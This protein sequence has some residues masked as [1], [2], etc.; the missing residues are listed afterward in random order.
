MLTILGMAKLPSLTLMMTPQILLAH[1][2][3]TMQETQ[4]KLSGD[5]LIHSALTH[6]LSTCA[7]LENHLADQTRSSIFIQHKM[8]VLFMS[9]ASKKE[10]VALIM[11]SPCAVHLHSS[12]RTQLVWKFTSM[13]GSKIQWAWFLQPAMQSWAPEIFWDLPLSKICM[14]ET[15]ISSMRKKL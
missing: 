11:W 14:L 10:K 12:S 1:Y 9:L 3:T 8:M 4:P 15:S 5:A 2:Y 7:H 6:T 13:N